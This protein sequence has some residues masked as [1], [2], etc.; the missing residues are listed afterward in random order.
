MSLYRA[1]VASV[2]VN[3]DRDSI[4]KR[5]PYPVYVAEG[6]R[7]HSYIAWFESVFPPADWFAVVDFESL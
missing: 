7:D 5:I 1:D 3:A 4:R 2:D 6:R